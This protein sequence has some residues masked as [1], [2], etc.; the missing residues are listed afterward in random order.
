MKAHPTSGT[1]KLKQTFLRHMP[2]FTNF[3][4]RNSKL[5]QEKVCPL[6]KAVETNASSGKPQQRVH[7]RCRDGVRREGR[8]SGR[9][10]RHGG[11]SP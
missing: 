4:V 2:D 11:G 8:C 9:V 3:E 1:E 5:Y 6:L 7:Y 10:S